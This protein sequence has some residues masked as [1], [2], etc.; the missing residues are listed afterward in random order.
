MN[1]AVVQ[2]NRPTEAHFTQATSALS[3]A[4]EALEFLGFRLVNRADNPEYFAEDTPKLLPQINITVRGGIATEV[5][6]YTPDGISVAIRDYD[7]AE[8]YDEPDPNHDIYEDE[9]GELYSLS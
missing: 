5:E 6:E 8:D 7:N 9:N 4:K 3:A 2:K 1:F